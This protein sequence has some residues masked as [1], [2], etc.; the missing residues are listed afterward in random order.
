M[1][2]VTATHVLFA[3]HQTQAPAILQ[4][5][6][7]ATSGGTWLVTDQTPFHP[8]SH[9]WPDHPADRGTCDIA[10]VAYPVIGCYTGAVELA[11]GQLFV[12][13]A[14]PVKRNEPGWVFVVVHQIAETVTAQPGESAL[15]QVDV[16]Y[17]QAL[18][19]GHSAGHL[20]S[21]A[22]N[23]V[24]HQDFWRKDASRK[25][26]LGHYDFHGYAQ[27][28]S[29]VTEDCS[30]DTYRLGK[31]LRKRGLNSAD[32]IQQLDAVAER[33][34]VLLETWR[35][36]GA[37]VTMRCEGPALTDSRYW[38]CELIPGSLITI[39]CGGTH[40]RSLADYARITVSFELKEEQELVMITR[41][42]A[43]DEA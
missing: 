7:A 11:S 42:A 13:Q 27:T 14:I 15:L 5:C 33:V 26:E 41:T 9:I 17:Q 35:Q 3:D 16:T 36:G 1:F 37:A 29:R 18:S 31:T 6:V 32:L 22:L 12:D 19:R 25:D 2:P 4:V 39:P 24:L 20:S 10:G 30:T 28:Q 38:Q 34:N 43:A 23:Q 21:L 8:V 40:V